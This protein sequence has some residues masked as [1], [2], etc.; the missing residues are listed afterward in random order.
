MGVF[1]PRTSGTGKR[2]VPSGK[3]S[4]SS[5]ELRAKRKPRLLFRSSGSFLLRYA[6]RQFLAS[7]FQLPPRITRFA[8]DGHS[9]PIGVTCG[10]YR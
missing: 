2:P 9:P 5:A 7:L 8:P 1:W 10:C 3:A 6:E 4:T